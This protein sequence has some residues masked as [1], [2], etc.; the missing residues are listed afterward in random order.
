MAL[1]ACAKEVSKEC[2]TL[3]GEEA[4]G[5][6][7]FVIEL[8]MVH[9]GEYGAAGSGFGVGGG[10]NETGDAGVKDRPGTHRAGLEGDVEDAVFE[11]VVAKMTSG[12]AEGDDLCVGSR[13]GVAENPILAAADDFTFVN[14]NCSYGNFAIGFGVLGFGDRGTE[15]FEVSHLK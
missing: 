13:V 9:D 6:F 5:D 12:F 7:D 3:V 14:D 4:G 2:A 11:A 10:V 8:G 1:A 15:V